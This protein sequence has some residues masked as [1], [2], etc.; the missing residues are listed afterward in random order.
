MM[1]LDNGYS[2]EVDKI[3]K[4]TWHSVMPNFDDASFYQTWSYGAVCWGEDKLSHL[5]LK[6]E[7]TIVSVAQLRIARFPLPG[8]GFA[9][10]VW[11][12]MWRSKGKSPDLGHLTNMLRALY[13]EYVVRRGYLLRV[14]PKQIHEDE[15]AV[16]EIFRSTG[17]SWTPDPQQTVYVDL[18]APIEQVRKNMRPKWRQT[19]NRATEHNVQF[20]D[21]LNEESYES[22][23]NV[24]KEM[25]K[26]KGYVEFGSQEDVLSVH[27]ELPEPLKLVFVNCVVEDETAAVLGWF[28]IGATG[29]PLVGATGEKALELNASYPMW[30]KMIEY[31]KDRG[32]S[33]V[34]L[35]GVNK[36]MNQGGYLFK[37]G[38]AGKNRLEKNYIG[39]FDAHD[40]LLS[41]TCF[42]IGMYLRKMY[43]D[44][45]LESNRV[46]RRLYA[47]LVNRTI[48]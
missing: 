39:Q 31:Y 1:E 42:S 12:P 30:W 29:H 13:K 18:S 26:R 43:R 35:A 25:K 24:V 11:G 3:D 15:D 22:V 2:Y 23:I 14:L 20:E 34:D 48:S 6:K 16:R 47:R 33:S 45:L 19:L 27:R 9:Y 46:V 37:T 41:F 10:L 36:E 7:G 38:L 21:G 40:G 32:A 44:L 8:A 28:P 5:V 17:Y 4:D